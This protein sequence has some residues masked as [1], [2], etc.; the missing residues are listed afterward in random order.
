MSRLIREAVSLLNH[1]IQREYDAIAACKTALQRLAS[2]DE[3]A[4]IAALLG[5]HREH[6]DALA[7]LVRNLGGEP[8]SQADLL[9]VTARGRIVLA[10]LSGEDVVLE[11]T[12]ASENELA[13]TYARAASQ[14]GLPVDVLD[15]LQRH[16]VEV[17][18]GRDALATGADE[19]L[20]SSRRGQ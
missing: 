16:A 13:L 4:R 14:P 6:I 18:Q 12:R 15:V 20:A 1:L 9:Q 11:A 17:E 10:G 2:D 8:A 5:R 3:R 19:A 7:L